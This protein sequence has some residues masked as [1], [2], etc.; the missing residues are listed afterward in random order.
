MT[1]EQQARATTRE[2]AD[3][4]GISEETLRWW[5]AEGRGPKSFN[6]GRRVFYRRADVEQWMAEQY[7]QTVRGG[8][9]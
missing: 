3:E 7:A 1:E 5:R 6:I 8:A 2:L 4:L 9:A